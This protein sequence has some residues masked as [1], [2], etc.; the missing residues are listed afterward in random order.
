MAHALV[1]KKLREAF[2]TLNG[3]SPIWF[4]ISKNSFYS[5]LKNPKNGNVYL[6]KISQNVIK[7]LNCNGG[8]EF[9]VLGWKIPHSGWKIRTN[10]RKLQIMDSTE[11]KVMSFNAI[12]KQDGVIYIV[13]ALTKALLVGREDVFIVLHGKLTNLKKRKKRRD[14][15]K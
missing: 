11:E 1:E 9:D 7:C 15:Y 10:G 12:P 14:I 13:S 3:S 2:G 6:P 4:T 5:K 8:H